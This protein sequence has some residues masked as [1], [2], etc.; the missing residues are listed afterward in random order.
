METS[1]GGDSGAPSGELQDQHLTV[2]PP[3]PGSS[4]V[5]TGP[6]PSRLLALF[7]ECVEHGIWASLES[8]TSR[9]EVV[10]DF[11]CRV[12]AA[13]NQQRQRN[14]TERARNVERTRRWKENRQQRRQPPPST[15][16]SKAAP[17]AKAVNVPATSTPAP[18][19]SFAQVV[20][21]S[22]TTVNATASVAAGLKG[23]KTTLAHP[24]KIAKTTLTA[25]RVSQRAALL[26]KRRAVAAV[27]EI[28]T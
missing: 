9:G 18:A 15:L 19:K 3:P 21:E 16:P 26:S 2:P 25:S 20:S 11:S 7:E 24:K 27:E 28:P 4:A 12:R 5:R 8:F 13:N 10:V 22:A 14:E 1:S 23:R 6:T 17:P